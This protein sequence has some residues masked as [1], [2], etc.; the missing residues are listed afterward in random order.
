MGETYENLSSMA[1]SNRDYVIVGVKESYSFRQNGP[2]LTTQ[3]H[4]KSPYNYLT[5]PS[6]P[7]GCS[8]IAVGQIMAYHKFPNLAYINWNAIDNT[9]AAYLIADVGHRV[10]MTYSSSGSWAL[11]GSVESGIKS[12]GY[13]VNRN[14][15]HAALDIEREIYANRPILM[16]GGTKNLPGNLALIGDGHYWVCDG[17]RESRYETLFFADFPPYG[18]T[19]YSGMNV[20]T[21]TDPNAGRIESYVNLHMNWGWGGKNDGWFALTDVNSGNGNYQYGR[22]YY[23]ISK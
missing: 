10:G 16:V 5:P 15:A 8:A 3:W 1:G 23:Y 6:H 12:Y 7:A 9:G 18:T 4:Q 22:Q 2:L 13:K 17:A 19:P 14:N 20:G 21:V 11:P